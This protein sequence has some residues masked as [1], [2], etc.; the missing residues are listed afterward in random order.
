M[1]IVLNNALVGYRLTPDVKLPSQGCNFKHI[2]MILIE[3]DG[4][5]RSLSWA[6]SRVGIIHVQDTLKFAKT[7][8]HL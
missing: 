7:Y 2:Q 8:D 3:S 5:G 4:S 1:T 6:Y